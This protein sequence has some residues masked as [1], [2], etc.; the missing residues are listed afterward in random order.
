MESTAS[1]RARHRAMIRK[2]G[3]IE[4]MPYL[5]FTER[6]PSREMIVHLCRARA[7]RLQQARRWWGCYDRKPKI[8]T[9]APR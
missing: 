9:G 7:R 6:S 5:V 2:L 1:G 8:R 3:Y 4:T